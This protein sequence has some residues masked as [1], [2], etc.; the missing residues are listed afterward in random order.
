MVNDT[1]TTDVGEFTLVDG[2]HSFSPPKKAK[3]PESA[4]KTNTS[5][6]NRFDPLSTTSESATITESVVTASES[7]KRGP[8]KRKSKQTRKNNGEDHFTEAMEQARQG[9]NTD[10]GETNRRSDDNGKQRKGKGARKPTHQHLPNP[11][12]IREPTEEQARAYGAIVGKSTVSWD[13]LEDVIRVDGRDAAMSLLIAL[14]LVGN[15]K[16]VPLE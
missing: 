16:R 11:I 7:P 14:A 4:S 9:S 15:G 5:S 8:K 3:E 1:T 13:D 10:R 2:K 6:T 12:M